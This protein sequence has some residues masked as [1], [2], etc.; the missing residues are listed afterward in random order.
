MFSNPVNSVSRCKYAVTT[1]KVD[2]TAAVVFSN[3]NLV[4]QDIVDL[5]TTAQSE[6]SSALIVPNRSDPTTCYKY[7]RNSISESPLVWEVLV[8]ASSILGFLR[9]GIR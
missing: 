9:K 3:Y 8:D 5:S 2:D 7:T 6:R 1:T 4:K